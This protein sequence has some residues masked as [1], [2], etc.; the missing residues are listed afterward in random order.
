[1]N[2]IIRNLVIAVP[3][4]TVGFTMVGATAATAGPNGPVIIGQPDTLPEPHPGPKFDKDLP[5][6]NAPKP[7]KPKPQPKPADQ[8]QVVVPQAD[9]VEEKKVVKVVSAKGSPDSIDRSENLFVA[10]PAEVE[11]TAD[12]N[13]GGLDITWLLVGGGVVTASGIAF[14]A[15]KRTN[16]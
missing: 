10:G 11:L 15:R 2:R 4:A 12:D 9:V 8:P 6:Q 16:A 14:A 7:N 1:M 3:L 5:L 13:N